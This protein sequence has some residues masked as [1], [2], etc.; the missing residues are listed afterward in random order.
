MGGP[1]AVVLPVF[2]IMVCGWLFARFRLI[3]E[4]GITGIVSFVFYLGIPALLFRTLSSG[5]AQRQLEADL[6]VAYFTAAIA[7][8][9]ATRFLARRVFGNGHRESAL[10]AMAATFSN[11]VLIGIP[12]IQRAY[13]DAGLVPQMLIVSVHA[14]I[15]FTLT[16]VSLEMGHRG[17]GSAWWRTMGAS[18]RSVFINPIII[19]GLGGLAWGFVG[20]P[21]PVLVDDFLSLLGRG[22][23]PLSLFAVGANLTTYRITGDLRE[24]VTM[25]VLK[26]FVLPLLVWLAC[27]QV[28]E[29]RSDWVT[30]AVLA[31]GMPAGAN[32]YVFA[33]RYETYVAR[34]SAVVLLSTVAS[35]V[36]LTVLLAVLPAP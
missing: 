26:L 19:G 22:A 12:L 6:I 34:A 7:L 16:T 5:A 4:A 32:V 31:A 29:V 1:V 21:L 35:A 10:A 36:T 24:S 13:G 11:N 8:F 18:L 9:L 15:L 25:L 14:T 3:T 27:T 20:P 17:G 33:R 2:A 23:A 28:W 30:V